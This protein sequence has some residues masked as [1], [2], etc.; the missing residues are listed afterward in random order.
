MNA[1]QLKSVYKYPRNYRGMLIVETK[2]GTHLYINPSENK[3]YDIGIKD[4][5]LGY[6]RFDLGFEIIKG[7][8]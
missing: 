3:I 4:A 6:N 1:K 8:S 2:S 7:I 5:L